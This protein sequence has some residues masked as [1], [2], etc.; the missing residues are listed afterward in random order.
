MVGVLVTL[1]DKEREE[2]IHWMYFYLNNG[3]AVSNPLYI[4]LLHP[5]RERLKLKKSRVYIGSREDKL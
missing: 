3:K 1:N 2:I 5:E 4:K